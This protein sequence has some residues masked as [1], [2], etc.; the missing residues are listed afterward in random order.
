MP[1]APVDIKLAVV[2]LPNGDDVLIL[3][4]R[5]LREQLGIEPIEEL[6]A[7]TLGLHEVKKNNQATIRRG[8]LTGILVI[9]MFPCH[10]QQHSNLLTVRRF[11]GLHCLNFRWALALVYHVV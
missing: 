3:R 6:K 4:S 11:R 1:R 10:Y 7:N 8:V 9:D 5:T 2:V